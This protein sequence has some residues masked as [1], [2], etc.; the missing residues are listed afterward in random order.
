LNL[1][2]AIRK[3]TFCER[4]YERAVVRHRKNNEIFEASSGFL[5]QVTSTDFDICRMAFSIKAGFSITT[6]MAFW[7][8]ALAHRPHPLHW[9]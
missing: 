6:D 9:L 2:G 1:Y 7:G 3:L 5:Y 4:N 8:H